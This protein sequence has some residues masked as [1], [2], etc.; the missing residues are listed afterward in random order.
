MPTRD[1][2]AAKATGWGEVGSNGSSFGGGG[3][4]EGDL[5]ARKVGGSP[6][7]RAGSL[8]VA[9]RGNATGP[10]HRS[11][12]HDKKDSTDDK[13]SN[14]PLSSAASSSTPARISATNRRPSI[15]PLPSSRLPF[16]SASSSASSSLPNP[17]STRPSAV[18][19][20][21]RTFGHKLSNSIAKPLHSISDTLSGTP[22]ANALP[23][24]SASVLATI[25]YLSNLSTCDVLAR[26]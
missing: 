5:K 6:E 23:S 13:L 16:P 15:P 10:I 8:P 7:K 2:S 12:S 26:H 3:G 21:P 25:K 14:L 1:A 17:Y 9:G 4:Y 11:Y 20:G 18:D 19:G 22:L 24:S